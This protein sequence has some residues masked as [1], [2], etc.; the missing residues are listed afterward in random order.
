M[1]ILAE[2]DRQQRTIKQEVTLEGIGLHSGNDVQ[3]N[4]LPAAVDSGIVFKRVDLDQSPQ[5]KANVANVVSTDRSTTVG[6]S[7]FKVQT[8]EHLMAALRAFDIDNILIEVNSEELPALDGSAKLYSQLFKEAGI[9][10]Q[11]KKKK[12]YKVKKGY[13]YKGQD[14]YIGIFPAEKYKINYLLKYDHPVIGT[15][16]FEYEFEKE[17]FINEIMPAR[18]FGFAKEVA[19]LKERGLAL[20]GSLDNAVLIEDNNVVNELRFKDEFVRHKVLDLVGDLYLNG[21]LIGEIIAIRTGHTD[22]YKL[23]QMIQKKKK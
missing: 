6:K 1:N 3:M 15:E 18:T 22:N 17:S 12:V 23:N 13:Y 8:I 5:V 19:M 4:F 20:G 7:G 16:Y 2:Y 11:A 14:T 10:R 21:P 9:E